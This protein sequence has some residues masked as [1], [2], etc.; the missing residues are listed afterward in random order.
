MRNMKTTMIKLMG[1]LNFS[2]LLGCHAVSVKSAFHTTRS[3]EEFDNEFMDNHRVP[4]SQK[5]THD[6]RLL[7]LSCQNP[8]LWY[9]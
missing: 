6:E 7:H 1:F 2:T 8:C 4:L 5:G 9:P 3:I